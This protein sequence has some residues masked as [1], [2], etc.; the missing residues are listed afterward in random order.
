MANLRNQNYAGN[1]M[2][3]TPK[4]I[5][6]TILQQFPTCRIF[7]E[8]PADQKAIEESGIDFTNMMIFCR[9]TKGA[10]TFRYVVKEDCLNSVSRQN[11]LNPLNEMLPRDLFSIGNDEEGIL[12]RNGTDK[13]SKGQQVNSDGHWAI[14]R[15]SLPASL[16]ERW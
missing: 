13:V 6:R 5:V 4:I 11:F 12:M 14:M 7:R 8:N 9:K 1:L 16:W 3:P 2:L 15:N 10:L